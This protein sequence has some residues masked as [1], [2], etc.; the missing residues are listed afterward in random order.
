V[1]RLLW[2]VRLAGWLD[3][4]S[5]LLLGRSARQGPAGFT[6]HDAVHDALGDLDLTVL[7][8]LDIGHQPP[9]LTL[10]N[11]APARVRRSGARGHSS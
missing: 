1:C 8:D 2:H 6:C 9:Q 5:G 10:V 4:A 3:G 7:Y 11:G